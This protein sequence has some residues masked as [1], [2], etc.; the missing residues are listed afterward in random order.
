MADY[1]DVIN[2]PHIGPQTRKLLQFLKEKSD[3]INPELPA[4]ELDELGDALK[5]AAS[6]IRTGQENSFDHLTPRNIDLLMVL[7][8]TRIAAH[9]LLDATMDADAEAN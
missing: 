4:R 5:L 8:E 3:S 6:K 9:A 1:D 7:A 2:D